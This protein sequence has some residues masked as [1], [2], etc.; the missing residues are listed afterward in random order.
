M[1]ARCVAMSKSSNLLGILSTQSST[2]TR[3]MRCSLCE[4]CCDKRAVRARVDRRTSHCHSSSYTF[5]IAL[6]NRQFFPVYPHD[7]AEGRHPTASTFVCPPTNPSSQTHA[8]VASVA[9]S[10]LSARL[11]MWPQ[12]CSPGDPSKTHALHL[13]NLNSFWQANERHSA[14]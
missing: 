9:T 3:A 6:A 5:I 1:R 4:S 7:M 13:R 11:G 8:L 14:T 2:V 10:N 12:G